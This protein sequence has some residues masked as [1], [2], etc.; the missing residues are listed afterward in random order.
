MNGYNPWHELSPGKGSPGVVDAFI[1]IA[2]GTR[3]KY[4]V[5][6]ETGMLRLDRILRTSMSYP[7]NYGFIPQTLTGDG[8]PL[9]ILVMTPYTLEPGCIVA[10]RVIGALSMEDTGEEDDKI[11]AVINNDYTSI[12]VQDINDLSPAIVKE[13]VHFFETYK[14]TENRQ[15]KITEV[16]DRKRSLKLIQES[17]SLYKKKYVK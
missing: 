1:E 10:A 9:D 14:L 16:L 11:I 5:D 8:D 7:G 6:K 15:V 4:E 2:F 12:H 17:V 13:L 3:T